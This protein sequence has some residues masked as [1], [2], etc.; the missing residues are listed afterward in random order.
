M[1]L[2]YWGLL[3]RWFFLLTYDLDA[4]WLFVVCGCGVCV[5]IELFYFYFDKLIL[6]SIYKKVA[7]HLF[8]GQNWRYQTNNTLKYLYTVLSHTVLTTYEKVIIFPS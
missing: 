1:S 4:V 5:I 3:V 6:I 2:I 8:R 7:V